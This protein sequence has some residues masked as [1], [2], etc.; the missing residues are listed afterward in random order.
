MLLPAGNGDKFRLGDNLPLPPVV[1]RPNSS[2]E[3]SPDLRNPQ[4]S[5]CTKP[6]VL[7]TRW[8]FNVGGEEPWEGA[9]WGQPG[10][11]LSLS[12]ARA[13]HRVYN[14][15]ATHTGAAINFPFA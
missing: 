3:A 14:S 9:A 15:A 7:Y 13:V 5:A 1:I 11:S 4:F 10:A 12:G 8:P 2:E 6:L